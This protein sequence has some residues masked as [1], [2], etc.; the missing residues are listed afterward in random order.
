MAFAFH[1]KYTR[2]KS[3]SARQTA[4]RANFYFRM[5]T[6]DAC[7]QKVIHERNSLP[8]CGNVAMPFRMISGVNGDAF[9]LANAN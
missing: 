9:F 5:L 7:G 2:A 3:N 1:H 8:H 4:K 6:L